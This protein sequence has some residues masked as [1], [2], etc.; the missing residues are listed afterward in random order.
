M[1]P[2]E[3]MGP[4]VNSNQE[5]APAI[6]S[7]L[8]DVALIDGAT[9]AAAAAMSLS[10]WHTLVRTANAPAPVIRQP[11]FTRWRIADVRAWLIDRA[12]RGGIEAVAAGVVERATK[13]SVAAKQRRATT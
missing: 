9:A 13:A 11:R 10:Q 1:A 5:A 8:S 4:T 3:Q 6:H 2:Y 12:E 7:A